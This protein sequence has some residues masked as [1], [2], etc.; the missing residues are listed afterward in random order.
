MLELQTIINAECALEFQFTAPESA[1][2]F[3]LGL[4]RC[5]ADRHTNP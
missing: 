4:R 3:R 1:A 2:F 5:D